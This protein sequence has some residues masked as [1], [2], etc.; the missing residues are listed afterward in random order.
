[1]HDVRKQ[2]CKFFLRAAWAMAAMLL[3]GGG[4]ATAQERGSI[5]GTV[6]DASGAGVPG[7]VVTVT[8]SRTNVSKPATTNSI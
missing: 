4:T 3:T 7:V 6:T 1:M 2:L 5:S 8:D